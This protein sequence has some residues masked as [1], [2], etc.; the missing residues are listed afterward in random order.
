M[1]I[2]E[3]KLSTPTVVQD[4]L[5]CMD[6]EWGLFQRNHLGPEALLMLTELLQ[7]RRHRQEILARGGAA[8]VRHP[9]SKACLQHSQTVIQWFMDRL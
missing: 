8:K 4:L 7:D 1:G 5:R 3:W 6:S 9:F 2:K